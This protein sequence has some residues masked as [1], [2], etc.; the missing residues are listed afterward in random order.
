MS[1]ATVVLGVVILVCLGLPLPLVVAAAWAAAP[2]FW[3][4]PRSF[5]SIL[6]CCLVPWTPPSP[7]SLRGSTS[8][9][10]SLAVSPSPPFLAFSLLEA[11]VL[12]HLARVPHF[13]DILL[14]FQLLPLFPFIFLSW[15]QSSDAFPPFFQS[16]S[17]HSSL[18]SMAFLLS[19]AFLHWCFSA[20][21]DPPCLPS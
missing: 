18:S 10:S 1:L 7:P 2:T 17:H 16:F 11:V 8:W 14:L 3:H 4:L 20:W 12:V 9:P 13:L 5:W 6:S 15:H 19:H 21:W